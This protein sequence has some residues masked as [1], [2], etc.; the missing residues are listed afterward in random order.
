M[1]MIVGPLTGSSQA[2]HEPPDLDDSRPTLAL[3]AR[4]GLVAAVRHGLGSGHNSGP[5][6]GAA[7]PGLLVLRVVGGGG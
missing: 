1:T 5:P 2:A 3:S 4:A 6:V 7:G